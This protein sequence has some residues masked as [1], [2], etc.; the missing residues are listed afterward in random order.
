MPYITIGLLIINLTATIVLIIKTSK[1]NLSKTEN[2]LINSLNNV[3]NELDGKINSLSEQIKS[4]DSNI[5]EKFSTYT[6]NSYLQFRQINDNMIHNL[7]TADKNSTDK[8]SSISTTLTDQ[9][10]MS[11]KRFQG[12]A[13][14]TFTKLE[15][16]RDTINKSLTSMQQDNNRKLDEMKQVVDEKLQDTLNKRINE[17]FKIVNERLEQV[18][19]GLGEMQTLAQGVGDLKKVLTNVKSRGILG[20]IQL[21]AILKEILSKEQYDE[22]VAT[23]KGSKNVVEFAI[24]LPTDNGDYIYLPIDSKFPGD[25]YRNLQ[26]AYENGNKEMIDAAAKQL[27]ATMKAE[28]KD[29]RDKY[30]SSPDTTE[31]GIMFLPFEGLYAEAVNRGLVEE[32]QRNYHVN[33]AGPSTMAAL[34]NSLQMG[35]KAFAIQKRS[36]EVWKVLGA[37]KTEID[38]FADVITAAQRKINDANSELDKLI[39]TRTRMI[40]SKLKSVE[41]V[42]YTDSLKLLESDNSTDI[43]SYSPEINNK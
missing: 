9:L 12:F 14:D 41:A 28:A 7:M 36:G 42:T 18:Y 17:S 31:F 40:Q 27:I 37:V 20:E 33:I 11:D 23:V 35:F 38:K 10:T 43:N 21:G 5:S 3:K 29:I 16:M 25:S 15:A 4:V 34:L 30:I 6:Q 19:K 2:T 32:L 8:L 24:K 1:A 13:S 39:T 22:N 26:E